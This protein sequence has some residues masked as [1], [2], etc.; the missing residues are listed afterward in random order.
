MAPPPV[1]D[2][3]FSIRSTSRTFHLFPF[4]PTELKIQILAYH[5]NSSISS[6]GSFKSY[7]LNNNHN[8]RLLSLRRAPGALYLAFDSK[9]TCQSWNCKELHLP[10]ALKICHLSRQ[11]MLDLLWELFGKGKADLQRTGRSYWWDDARYKN[12]KLRDFRTVEV[13]GVVK[14]EIECRA[15]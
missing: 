15:W 9:F 7:L 2:K 8:C 13:P 3:P 11:V 10:P 1:I 12:V 6:N 14:P 5:A 4:L